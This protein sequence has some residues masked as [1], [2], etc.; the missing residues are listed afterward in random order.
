MINQTKFT[1]TKHSS[2]V[3]SKNTQNHRTK[4]PQ[5]P[6]SQKKKKTQN[7]LIPTNHKSQ[8]PLTLTTIEKTRKKT[9]HSHKEPETQREIFSDF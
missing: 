9:Q 2:Q 3:H 7:P 8:N 4:K 1:A 6:G 5:Q